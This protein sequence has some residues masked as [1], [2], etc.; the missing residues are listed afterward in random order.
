M[1]DCL[2]RPLSGV[3]AGS[4]V[5]LRGIRAGRELATRLSAMGFVPGEMLHV[6]CN[7]RPGPLVVG[8]KGSR[9]MLGRGMADKM[10]VE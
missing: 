5:T 9:M 4:T 6:H 10:A 1:H 3:L 7:A 2:R 8:V